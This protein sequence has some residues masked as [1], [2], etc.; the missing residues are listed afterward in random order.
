MGR[1]CRDPCW[2]RVCSLHFVTGKAASVWDKY[3]IDWVPTQNLGKKVFKDDE[4]KEREQSEA[5]ARAERAKDRRK[6]T[7]EQQEIE[8]AKKRKELDQSGCRAQDIPFSEVE[9]S[10]SSSMEW[11]DP[12]E[13]LAKV[14]KATQT[15]KPLET[16]KAESET[17]TEVS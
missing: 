1:K 17:Q 7:I 11:S 10:T 15:D 4:K 5:I 3:N 12:M 16:G 6:R 14:D 13:E 8:A 9:P 2:E